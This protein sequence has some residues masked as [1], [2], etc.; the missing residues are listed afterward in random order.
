ML[1]GFGEGGVCLCR[2]GVCWICPVHLSSLSDPS[3]I[4]PFLDQHL[5]GRLDSFLC[6]GGGSVTAHVVRG[7]NAQPRVG[8]F[9]SGPSVLL[10]RATVG[11]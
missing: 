7:L 4:R 2:L 11:D 10:S 8:L 5:G 1:G 6:R 9:A 3:L